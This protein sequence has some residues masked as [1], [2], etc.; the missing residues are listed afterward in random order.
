[1]MYL[2]FFLVFESMCILNLQH[3]FTWTLS[4]HLLYLDFIPFTVEKVYSHSQVYFFFPNILKCLPAT[5]M[6]ITFKF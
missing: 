4:F 3:T 6:S 1:M 2:K 5:E